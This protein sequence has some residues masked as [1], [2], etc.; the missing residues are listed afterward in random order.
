ML[1]TRISCHQPQEVGI[2]PMLTSVVVVVLRLEALIPTYFR[3]YLQLDVT[4]NV[5]HFLSWRAAYFSSL[6][7]VVRLD[8][9]LS[10]LRLRNCCHHMLRQQHNISLAF[11]LIQT[12]IVYH[13]YAAYCIFEKQVI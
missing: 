12:L 1:I 13:S 7:G 11:I 6:A 9:R 2:L 3:A 5:R 10:A 4:G 8:F